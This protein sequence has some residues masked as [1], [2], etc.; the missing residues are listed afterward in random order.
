MADG[1]VAHMQSLCNIIET[2]FGSAAA[3]SATFGHKDGDGLDVEL[4]DK[5][6]QGLL[7]EFA[8]EER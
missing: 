8:Y 7:L 4:L 3:I 2:V 5:T 1:R 6:Q